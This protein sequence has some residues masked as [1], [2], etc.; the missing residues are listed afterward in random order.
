MK[1]YDPTKVPMPAPMLHA[2]QRLV[3]SGF[4]RH[5]VIDYGDLRAAEVEEYWRS[6]K[7]ELPPLDNIL[8]DILGRIC[9]T[10]IPL[11]HALRAGGMEIEHKAEAEQAAAIHWMLGFYFRH[12]A[13]WRAA[14]MVELDRMSGKIDVEAR[15][16]IEPPRESFVITGV[17]VKLA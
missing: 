2:G 1:P 16:E 10:I 3:V 7:P 15:I 4:M 8:A 9:F 14:A 5:Q 11:V 17:E 13:E 6:R 12:G